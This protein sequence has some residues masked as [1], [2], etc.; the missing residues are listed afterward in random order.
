VVGVVTANAGTNLNTSALSTAALQGTNTATTAHTCSVAG[1][2]ELGCLG[3]VDDDIK[4]PIPAGTNQ[5]GFVGL[6]ANTTGGCGGGALVTTGGF[7]TAATNNA[8]L[9]KS[10]A[11]TLCSWDFENTSTT[12]LFSI[13]FYDTATAPAAGVPCNSTTN[14]IGG[15]HVAQANA[16]S[17]GMQIFPGNAY[18]FVFTTGLVVCITGGNFNADNTNAPLGGNFNFA[19]K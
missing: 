17:P 14:L 7:L 9:L 3:Q 11:G 5:I 10:G 19:L 4:G 12:G 1:F 16:I 8:T 6:Q 2:S 13:R 15:N 18:G